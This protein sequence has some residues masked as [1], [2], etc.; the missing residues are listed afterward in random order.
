MLGDACHVSCANSLCHIADPQVVLYNQQT[1]ALSKRTIDLD[2]STFLTFN[3]VCCQLPHAYGS[4]AALG[5]RVA[6]MPCMQDT[7]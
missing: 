2:V 4:C 7:G 1:Y 3:A 5:M 6:E